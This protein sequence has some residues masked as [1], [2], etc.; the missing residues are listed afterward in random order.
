[1]ADRRLNAR[2][3]R[4]CTTTARQACPATGFAVHHWPA[5]KIAASRRRP[6][7][8]RSRRRTAGWSSRRRWRPRRL[9]N[10]GS[11]NSSIDGKSPCHP[12]RNAVLIVRLVIWVRNAGEG[13]LRRA[14]GV[15]TQSVLDAVGH[16]IDPLLMRAV[17]VVGDRV[18]ASPF[19]DGIGLRPQP[20]ARSGSKFS[21]SLPSMSGSNPG[22]ELAVKSRA[23]ARAPEKIL[24]QIWSRLMAAE[25]ARRRSL[26][27]SP[28]KC[29]SRS[30][31]SRVWLAAAG[32]RD[33]AVAEVS[34]VDGQHAG[35]NGVQHIEIA[36]QQ[37]GVGGVQ[38]GV[39]D[40][41]QALVL[42][43]PVAVVAGIGHQ[44]EFDVVLPGRDCRLVGESVRAVADRMLAECR[45][46]FSAASGSG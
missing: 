9:T 41:P 15:D 10:S 17:G 24:R 38:V 16:R 39:E 7:R 46:V 35:R 8:R 21:A 29:G 44:V 3:P 42:R 28:A 19:R 11:R 40:E 45:H 23:G 26:P 36:R 5:R 20:R 4:R 1:M 30:G 33:R 31:V 37:V 13:R 25:S 22:S 18:S 2:P 32:A 27:S 34:A 14:D 12:A 6:R 43:H